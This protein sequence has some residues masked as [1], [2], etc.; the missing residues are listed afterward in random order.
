MQEIAE[1]QM[2]SDAGNVHDEDKSGIVLVTCKDER[3]CLELQ[4]CILKGPCQVIV[5][6]LNEVSINLYSTTL[7]L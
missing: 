4:E 2:K 6:V 3:T 1:E 5:R 7:L